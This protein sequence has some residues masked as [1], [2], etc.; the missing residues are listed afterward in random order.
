MLAP[1]VVTHAAQ[2]MNTFRGGIHL[3]QRDRAVV[4]RVIEGN[5]HLIVIYKYRIYENVNDPPLAVWFI[6]I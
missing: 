6:K 2:R 1:M 5:C 3:R 4:P